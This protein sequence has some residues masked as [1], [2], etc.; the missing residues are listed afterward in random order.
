MDIS[1]GSQPGA[2]APSVR[3]GRVREDPRN[4]FSEINNDRAS[5]RGR[6]PFDFVVNDLT[7]RLVG[8]PHLDRS[9]AMIYDPVLFYAKR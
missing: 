5:E 7:G 3:L 8:I 2:A 4:N 6:A 1:V 9:L